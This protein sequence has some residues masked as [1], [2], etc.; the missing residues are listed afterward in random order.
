MPDGATVPIQGVVTDL[1]MRPLK[2]KVDGKTTGK[3]I[4][5]R[6]LSEI[7]QAGALLLGQGS[8]NQPLERIRLDA[9]A[10]KQ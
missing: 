10:D 5:V 8:L 9:G 2:G 3:N 6:S 1:D 4:L 7:A